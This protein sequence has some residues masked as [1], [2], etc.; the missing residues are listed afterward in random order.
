MRQYVH[1]Q[2]VLLLVAL[3]AEPVNGLAYEISQSSSKHALC[4]YNADN[5]E[6]V[7]FSVHCNHCTFF[8][9]VDDNLVLPSQYKVYNYSVSNIDIQIVRPSYLHILYANNRSPPLI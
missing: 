1:Y 7:N 6:P 5:H 4:S 9:D 2:I 3:L 8:N